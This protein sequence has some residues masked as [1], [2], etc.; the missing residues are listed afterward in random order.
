MFKNYVVLI[1]GAASG[2]GLAAARL[3]ISENA[4][5]IG[6]DLDQTVLENIQR[7]LGNRFIPRQCDV[8]DEKC[9]AEVTQFVASEYGKIDTLVNNAGRGTLV[10]M[11]Y[12]QES[13]FYWHYDANVKGPMLMVKHC[14][15]LLKESNNASIVNISSSAARVEHTKNHFLYSTAKAALLKF[16]QHIVRDFPGIRANTILPGWVDT[17]I[18]SR[19]GID[20]DTIKAIYER[21][22]Q[23]IPAGRIGS[24]DEIA[25]AIL[26]LS[27]NRA[28]YINGASLDI[29]GG[30]MCNAD[31]GFLF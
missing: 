10:M 1:T 27:S 12:M 23:F 2:I 6:V 28:S 5:V 15:P 19:A 30:M 31:W 29:N 20:D 8:T 21:A 7:D 11:E 3:F 16:T 25:H 17:P 9:I 4:T 26:F 22:V 14:I 18:Y 24:T 13:D